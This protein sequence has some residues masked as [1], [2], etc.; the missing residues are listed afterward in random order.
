MKKA[1]MVDFDG[2]I[3]K[4]SKRWYDGT[5]YDTPMEGVKESLTFLKENFDYN[6]IIFTAR[7]VKEYREKIGEWLNKFGIPFDHISNVKTPEGVIFIDDNGFR[8]N[9]WITDLSKII[10]ILENH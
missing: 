5:I 9:N 10:K 7:P 4:Y 1:I 8:F 2:V 3:H 6:I